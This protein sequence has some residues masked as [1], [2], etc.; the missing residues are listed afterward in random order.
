MKRKSIIVALGLSLLGVVLSSIL[1]SHHYQFL[2]RVTDPN[3][4]GEKSFCTL[5]DWINCDLINSSPYAE[6]FGIPLAGLGLLYYLVIFGASLFAFFSSKDKKNPLFVCFILSG[7]ALLFT[8]YTVSISLVKIKALCLLC[9]GL[10]AVNIA[11]FALL[12]LTFGS[13]IKKIFLS[14]RNGNKEKKN[15]VDPL[16]FRPKLTLSI[17]LVVIFF[18]IGLLALHN[19]GEEIREEIRKKAAKKIIKPPIQDIPKM[20]EQHFAQKPAPIAIGSRPFWGNVKAP[21][22]IVEFSDF[23]C[24]FCQMAAETLKPQLAEYGDD[25]LFYFANYPLDMSCNP[26]VTHAM[27][28]NACNAAKAVLCADKEGQFWPYHDILFQNQKALS[29]GELVSYGEQLKLDKENFMKCLFS[30]E[31]TNLVKQDIEL[32]KSLGITG[33]PSLFL[34]GRPLKGWNNPDFLKAVIEEELKRNNQPEK[35]PAR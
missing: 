13:S 18:G 17:L 10:Y 33:T 21:I 29:S 30:E 12:P 24:P 19:K 20:V 5:N 23:Q 16:G 4:P 22:T 28:E 11:L 3:G 27:H 2:E 31:S 32:G 7:F 14:L 35:I 8:F 25:I 6:I 34:N 26:Y 1:L 15:Q 9:S